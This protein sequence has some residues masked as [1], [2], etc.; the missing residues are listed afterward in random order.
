MKLH[1]YE[2]QY[3]TTTITVQHSKSAKVHWY[4]STRRIEHTLTI[5]VLYSTSMQSGNPITVPINRW[6][7]LS[8]ARAYNRWCWGDPFISSLI[9][10]QSVGYNYQDAVACHTHRIK[11]VLYYCITTTVLHSVVS[12]HLAEWN[13]RSL[14]PG[15]EKSSIQHPY[16]S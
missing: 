15:Y 7:E 11:R 14:P 3:T 16:R 2:V 12:S 10:Q 13:P 5:T 1:Y 9:T 4:C 8:G 6:I